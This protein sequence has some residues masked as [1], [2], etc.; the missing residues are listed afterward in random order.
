MRLHKQQGSTLVEM[1]IVLILFLMV[2]FAV[3]EFS[4]ATYRAAQL[5]DATREGL[6]YA[7]VNDPMG[8]LPTCPGGG[9]ISVDASP[10]MV[11]RIANFAPIINNQDDIEI[12]VE[13]SCPSSGYIGGD[14]VYLVTVRIYGAKHYLT[15]PEVL[16]LNVAI[17][18]S[19]FKATRISEDLHTEVQGE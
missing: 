7:I 6:R 15:V 19:E 11:N 4:I 2:V 1:A 5:S 12:K 10:E 3:M 17:E 9:T 16:G 18:L 14:D 8:T 13:Y